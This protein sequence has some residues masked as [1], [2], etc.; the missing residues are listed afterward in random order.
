MIRLDDIR[1]RAQAALPN[2]AFQPHGDS[3]TIKSYTD[4]SA[5]EKAMSLPVSYGVFSGVNPTDVL[6]SISFDPAANRM[7]AHHFANIIS[8]FLADSDHITLSSEKDHFALQHVLLCVRNDGTIRIDDLAESGPKS[9]TIDVLVHPGV[10]SSLLLRVSGDFP[11][12]LHI[13]YHLGDSSSVDVS[14]VVIGKNAHVH[15]EFFLNGSGASVRYRGASIRGRSDVV[16]D[17]FVRGSDNFARV[18][19]ALFSAKSDF[20]VHRGVIRVERQSSGANVDMDSAF[21]TVGGLAVNVPML[22]VLTSDVSR[23]SHRAR[24]L[25]L[26][27]ER[28][29][30]LQ[31]RGLSLSSAEELYVSSIMRSFA[32]DLATRDFVKDAIRSFAESLQR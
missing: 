26:D 14:S 20:L 18:S 5:F 12:H 22:E 4:W 9:A 10:S 15:H 11:Q 6:A 30:Y 16:T 19:H 8:F 1:K 3:P 31:T 27:S 29:F 32:G 24:D 7:L 21:Y 2:T 25:A 28:L 23:A 17:A 13:R